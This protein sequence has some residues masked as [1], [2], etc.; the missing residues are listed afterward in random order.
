MS[1]K[2]FQDVTQKNSIP[3]KG[4]TNDL[5][6]KLKLNEFSAREIRVFAEDLEKANQKKEQK[7][8]EHQQEFRTE[9]K[10][11]SMTRLGIP[12]VRIA[13][14]LNIH[15]ET[16]TKYASKNDDLFNKILQDSK[17]GLRI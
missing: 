14:R 16:I 10:V 11:A 6:P 17:N 12:L 5:L 2:V 4:R 7:K 1:D 8:D 13:R 9:I 15:R 3:F